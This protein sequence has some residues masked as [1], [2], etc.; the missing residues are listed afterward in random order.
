M[1]RSRS[2]FF[3]Q[4]KL[5]TIKKTIKTQKNRK[6]VSF[7]HTKRNK[8]VLSLEL[9]QI[10]ARKL[11][12]RNKNIQQHL[13]RNRQRKQKPRIRKHHRKKLQNFLSDEAKI[14][15]YLKVHKRRRPST[16]DSKRRN[17][18]KQLASF[19]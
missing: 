7:K 13:Q 2:P 4:K 17:R 18:T 15:K 19:Y 10:Q 16:V 8:A 11:S 5:K 9:N 6:K 1:K 14:P 12:K 3:P